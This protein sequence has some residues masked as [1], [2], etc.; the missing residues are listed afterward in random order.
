MLDVCRVCL[1]AARSCPAF[2]S[3]TP[4]IDEV[5]RGLKA[6]FV[7]PGGAHIARTGREETGLGECVRSSRERQGVRS[8]GRSLFGADMVIEN[9]CADQWVMSNFVAWHRLSVDA[10]AAD[11]IAV[12]RH[13]F[14]EAISD[15]PP[16]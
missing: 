14:S 12:G 7:R 3:A 11:V 6:N 1:L 2:G 5:P 10:L 8:E 15:S 4:Q 16:Q 13:S 9:A